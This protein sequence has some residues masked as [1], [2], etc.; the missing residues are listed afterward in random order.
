MR[1]KPAP[2]LLR[3][4]KK[5]PPLEMWAP[6]GIESRDKACRSRRPIFRAAVW[7]LHVYL[8]SV[9]EQSGDVS[10]TLQLLH[11][12]RAYAPYDDIA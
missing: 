5:S 8:T 3:C 1:R 10:L 4:A 11:L 2:S 9:P 12:W 7:S 6:I